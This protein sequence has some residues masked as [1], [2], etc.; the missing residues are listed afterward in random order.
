MTLLRRNS[1][2]ITAVALACAGCSSLLGLDD[3]GYVTDGGAAGDAV[4]PDADAGALDAPVT[5]D[6]PQ[7]PVPREILA[8]D[9]LA[10]FPLDEAAGASIVVDRVSGVQATVLGN[11]GLGLPGVA[12]ASARFADTKSDYIA[13]PSHYDFADGGSF[14]I[15]L[16]ARP[17]FPSG[18]AQLVFE[19]AGKSTGPNGYILYFGWRS[20]RDG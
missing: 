10:Y 14:T 16:W 20:D 19:G 15:E 12:G 1:L 11:V 8:D 9:P 5:P 2:R 3:V 7:G 13:V 17:H 6:A 18:T 4:Q